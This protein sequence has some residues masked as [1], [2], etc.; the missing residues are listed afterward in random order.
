MPQTPLKKTKKKNK[1]K[2]HLAVMGG[3][4]RLYEAV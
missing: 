3:H 1:I 4:S 2:E